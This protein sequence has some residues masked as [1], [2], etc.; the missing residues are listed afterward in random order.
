MASN[1]NFHDGGGE[2]KKAHAVLVCPSCGK[3]AHISRK[4]CGCHA[5]LSRAKAA[6]SE[7]PPEA[8]PCNFETE[9]LHCGDCPEGCRRCASFGH[10]QTNGAGFGGEDCRHNAGTARCGCCQA[11]VKI[12]IKL[13]KTDFTELIK[14]LLEKRAPGSPENIYGEIAGF[15]RSGMV[16]PVLAR[17]NR[18]REK[19]V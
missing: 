3:T 9:G 4:Y 15:I 8:G 13:G 6:M 16:K 7:E 19:A 2:A 10:P 18:E 1:R 17:I 11:Q 14:G 5:D 12:A